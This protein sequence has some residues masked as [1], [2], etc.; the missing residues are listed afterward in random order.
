MM[1]DRRI[2]RGNT[3]SGTILAPSLRP[4]A[5]VNIRCCVGETNFDNKITQLIW[6]CRY[7]AGG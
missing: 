4:G 5:A 2:V 1:S 3:Y 7:V 6:E